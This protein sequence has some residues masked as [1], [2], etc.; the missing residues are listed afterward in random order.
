MVGIQDLPINDQLLFF[1]LMWMFFAL[2]LFV[3]AV[4]DW[5]NIRLGHKLRRDGILETKKGTY[6]FT[7]K[8]KEHN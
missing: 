4:L 8:E 5:K 6:T 3:Y 1:Q 7:P 2:A